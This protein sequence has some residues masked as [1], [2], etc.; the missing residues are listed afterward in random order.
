VAGRGGGSNPATGGPGHP[1]A[2]LYAPANRGPGT[3]RTPPLY[4]RP[5]PVN[6]EFP[7][8]LY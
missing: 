4:P 7:K 5:S 3:P 1:P 2:S 8:L 6:R